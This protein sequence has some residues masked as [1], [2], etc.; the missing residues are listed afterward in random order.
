MSAL[1]FV[2]AS[3]TSIG[4]AEELKTGLL[5]VAQAGAERNFV[6]A[7]QALARRLLVA[8]MESD[9]GVRDTPPM[10][11]AVGSERV[12]QS[13]AV[14][15]HVTVNGSLGSRTGVAVDVRT[16]APFASTTA[17]RVPLLSVGDASCSVERMATFTD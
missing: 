2:S 16:T 15:V 6:S 10:A 4:K 14:S 17:R 7:T 5:A 9:A 1:T 3:R 11:T 13:A 8:A 12:F